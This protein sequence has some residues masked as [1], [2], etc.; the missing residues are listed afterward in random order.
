MSK[1][2]ATS[3]SGTLIIEDPSDDEME[4]DESELVLLKRYS[5]VENIPTIYGAFKSKQTDHNAQFSSAEYYSDVPEILNSQGDDI[6]YNASEK[7]SNPLPPELESRVLVVLDCA[8][9][10][11]EFTGVGEW[12]GDRSFSVEG[13]EK[14][15]EYFSHLPVPCRIAAFIPSSYLSTKPKD[16]SKGNAKMITDDVVKL[17]SMVRAGEVISVKTGTHDDAVM[18]SYARQH[19]GYI[20]S[21]DLFND[22]VRSMKRRDEQ[23]GAELSDFVETFRAG[24]TFVQGEFV[25]SPDSELAIR[26]RCD[27]VFVSDTVA[28]ST[29]VGYTDG[30]LDTS[31]NSNVNVYNQLTGVLNGDI[32]AFNI[33]H[34]NVKS[35]DEYYLTGL[36]QLIA[37]AKAEGAMT[38]LTYLLLTRAHAFVR[39]GSVSL[40]VVDLNFILMHIVS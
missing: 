3:R 30:V 6:A 2:T 27:T 29:D 23:I 22:H 17:E 13:L 7:E 39:F 34:G 5:A 26:L 16:G 4:E 12:V 25:L 20:V 18:I 19:H 37:S 15:F 31:I 35:S 10:G 24:F 40:A 32:N 11:H 9:I 21:N 14:A 38:E 33:T 8:N 36:D 28:A 1:P